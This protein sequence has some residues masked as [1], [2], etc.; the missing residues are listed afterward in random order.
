LLAAFDGATVRE[1][2][3]A[4]SQ[5]VRLA[6]LLA[7]VSL[8]SD[9]AHDVPAVSTRSIDFD[10][11]HRAYLQPGIHPMVKQLTLVSDVS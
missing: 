5:G 6:E 4:G 8:A 10:L 11:G 2:Q 7:T 3:P 1:M 9:L